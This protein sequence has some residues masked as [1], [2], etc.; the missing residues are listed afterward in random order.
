MLMLA[1]RLILKHCLQF[2]G[3]KLVVEKKKKKKK[4][5][6]SGKRKGCVE[7]EVWSTSKYFALGFQ[8]NSMQ[9]SV[10]FF[11]CFLVIKGII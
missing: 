11:N 9:N 3:S 4:K 5:K 8:E 1:L 2:V 7:I 6:R 10:C